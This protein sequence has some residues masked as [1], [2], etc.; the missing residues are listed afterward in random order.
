MWESLRIVEQCAERLGGLEGAPVM[1]A[2][3]K[4]AWPSQL[5]VGTDGMGNSAQP[6]QATS[7]GSRWRR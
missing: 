5:A 2:D 7:W 4:I 3:K 6:H 1:V